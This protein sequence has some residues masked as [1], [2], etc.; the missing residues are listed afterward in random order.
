MRLIPCFLLV[1]TL[2][3][4]VSIPVD[5]LTLSSHHLTTLDENSN[6]V[7]HYGGENFNTDGLGDDDDDHGNEYL[8]KGIKSV[9]KK[10][11]GSPSPKPAPPPPPPKPAPAPKAA[12][13]PAPKAA[14]APAPKAAPAPAPKAAPAPAPKAAPAPAPKAAPAPAPKAAPAPAP[15]TASVPVV[16]APKLVVNAPSPP[17]QV[18]T[19]F[20]ISMTCDN[21]FDLYVAGKKVG[22][23]DTWTTTYEFSPMVKPGDV[24]AIDGVDKGGPAAFIGVFNGKPSKAADW[25]CTTSKFSNWNENS[26]DDSAWPRAVSYSRN[27][28]NNV[29]RSVSG[30]SRPKIPADAEW[31]WTSNNENHN[32]VYCRY[33][34]IPKVVVSPTPNPEP[35][36]VAVQPK[37]EAPKVVVAPKSVVSPTVEAPKVVVA[38]KS[39][40]SPTVEAPKVVVAPKPVVSPTIEAPKVVVAPKPVVSPTVEAPKVVVSSAPVVNTKPVVIVSTPAIE[41]E[42]KSVSSKVV[43]EEPEGKG[44]KVYGNYCGPNYCGGQKFKGAEG[45]KCQWGVPPKDSLDECCKLH[46]QCCG[47]NRSA[48]CNKEILS[49]INKVSCNDAKCILAQTAMKATFTL[50]KNKVCGELIHRKQSSEFSASTSAKSFSTSADDV[51]GSVNNMHTRV[52]SIIHETQTLQKREIEQNKK[53]VNISQSDL[54]NVIMKQDVEQQQL[55][56]LKASILRTNQSIARHYAQMNADSLYLHKLDLI[57]PQFL[58]TLDATN[59]NFATLSEH[60]SKLVSDEHKKFM[61]DILARARNATVYDTRD[62]A[63]AFL[64]HYEKYKHV[65]RTESTTYN[66][67]ELKLKELENRYESGEVVFRGLKAEVAR[68][69]ELLASLKKTVAVSES[70]AELFVQIEQIISSIL[71][72][73]KTKFAI[74]GA[75]KECAVSVLKSHVANGLV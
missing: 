72:S 43:E 52:V 55:T 75:E 17:V 58:Q 13:A 31:I 7:E 22:K 51:I 15:K 3:M 23:G 65:L 8:I 5:E 53:N 29:W 25:K 42:L 19:T 61:E 12:P 39:V 26:F 21:E 33:T 54:D 66:K 14:P 2:S 18:A 38:P 50:M 67:D 68:L 69:R 6:V 34:P 48:N 24:I 37:A 73:K 40:V 56:E 64:A 28:D 32:K 57:K 59:T 44:F 41:P 71:S 70:E 49:C 74:D 45:P 35:K 1:C 62:L 9:V 27:Q 63:Q 20:P 60:V 47:L 10:V 30:G 36:N 4:A 16:I 11:F 46:D